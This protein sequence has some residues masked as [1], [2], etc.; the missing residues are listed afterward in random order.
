MIFKCIENVFS[1]ETGGDSSIRY[2][3]GIFAFFGFGKSPLLQIEDKYT[4]LKIERDVFDLI[5]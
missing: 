5:V 4:S 2:I 1:F 3:L